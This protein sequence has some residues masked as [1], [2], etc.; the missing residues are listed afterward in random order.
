MKKENIDKLNKH[1]FFWQDPA[2]ETSR[3]V[4]I[5]GIHIDDEVESIEQLNALEPDTIIF[6]D[7][8]TEVYNS[9]LFICEQVHEYALDH[10]THFGAMPID[11]MR[12]IT[13]EDE[14]FEF[15]LDFDGIVASL[16]DEQ[17][18]TLSAMID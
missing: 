17:H 13:T 12:Y 9:E 5:E 6:V 8:G 10:V 11:M 18:K 4:S 2:R 15:L 14:E 7:G 3:I 16:T 1:K